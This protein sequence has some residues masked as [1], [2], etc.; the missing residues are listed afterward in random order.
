MQYLKWCVVLGV[1]PAALGCF[2]Y[3]PLDTSSRMQ[4]GE[5]VAVEISDRGRTE[6]SDRL[7][8]GVLRLEGTLTRTDSAELVMNVW[9]VSQIDGATMRWSGE[10]VRFKREYASRV[11]SRTLN[12]GKTIL[13]S[14][15]AVAGLVLFT[16]QFELFGFST[17]D[18][19]PGDSIPP[20]SSRGWWP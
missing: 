18:D 20:A 5:H 14:G 4:A 9:R 13:V 10:S 17:G 7:G 12:R 6:L 8:T 15:A 1:T 2:Q 11:Q 16:R 3:A 19:S